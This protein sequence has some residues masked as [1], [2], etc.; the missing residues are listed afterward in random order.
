[1]SEGDSTAPVINA[2]LDFRITDLWKHS[3]SYS[4]NVAQTFGQG[5][6]RRHQY[7][8]RRAHCV[9]KQ[10][11]IIHHVPE[12]LGPWTSTADLRVFKVKFPLL[13]TTLSTRKGCPV[14]AQTMFT[15]WNITEACT[16]HQGPSLMTLSE[17]TSCT[18]IRMCP[19]WTRPNFGK[20]SKANPTTRRPLAGYHSSCSRLCSSQVVLYVST[21]P[22]LLEQPSDAS[23]YVPLAPLRR[24][25]FGSV[26]DAREVFYRRA[27]VMQHFSG[28]M[29]IANLSWQSLFDFGIEDDCFCIAQGALLLSYYSTNLERHTN[30]FWL[31]V[32]I[33]NARAAKAQLYYL[34]DDSSRYIK[35]MKKRL[36]WCCIL[37]DRILPLGLRRPLNITLAHFHFGLEP[38]TED[39]MEDEIGRSKVYDA[40]TQRLLARILVAQC[41]LA[42][43][44]TD[45]IMTL[46]PVNGCGPK[47]FTGRE[48][49]VEAQ[50]KLDLY[51]QK[52][53]HWFNTFHSWVDTR[54]SSSET[55]PSVILYANLLFIYYR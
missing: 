1:L 53:N 7:D 33:D 31:G 24:C 28:D 19:C 18:S 40:N 42:A 32:A 34:D 22:A 35:R 38:L 16:F 12:Y 52:L 3:I 21:I 5:T 54:T 23:K 46:Y 14:F 37:R 50:K 4:A 17:N 51:N 27:K 15:T 10:M 25:G 6:R 41:G 29:V 11:F 36:W 13:T 20:F 48:D 39:D 26:R 8:C 45:I 55:H 44:L 49:T 30:S 9:A 43:Q 2:T 47:R